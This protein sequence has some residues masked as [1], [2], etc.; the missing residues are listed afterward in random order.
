M[1][2]ALLVACEKKGEEQQD[3]LLDDNLLR[4]E[5]AYQKVLNSRQT[6]ENAAFA[7]QE[8]KRQDDSLFIRVLGGCSEE[9]YKIIWNGAIAESHPGQVYLAL[10][11]EPAHDICQPSAEFLLKINLRK[12][13]GKAGSPEDFIFH[14]ANGSLKQNKSLYPDGTV[15]SEE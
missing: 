10:T 12:I 13:I 11:H 8:V 6:G 14:L 3:V 4:S 5:T 15:S 7:I 2:F 9:S 1:L